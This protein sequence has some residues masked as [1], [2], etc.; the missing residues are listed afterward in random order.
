MP[1]LLAITSRG[2]PR[3]PLA[4]TLTVLREAAREAG[5]ALTLVADGS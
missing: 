1:C 3:A 4:D 2:G 5:I